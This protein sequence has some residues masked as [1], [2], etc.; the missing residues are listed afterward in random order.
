VPSFGEWGFNLA[1]K[2]PGFVPPTRYSVPTRFLDADST[3][4]MFSFPPDMRPLPVEPN[5]LNTQALVHYFEEDW[6]KVI[7]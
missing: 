6:G 2:R 3:R 1:M 4:L 7:R 5:H